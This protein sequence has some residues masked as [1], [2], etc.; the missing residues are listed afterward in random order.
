MQKAA[1]ISLV[2][3]LLTGCDDTRMAIEQM[4]RQTAE[5]RA[6]A[7][8]ELATRLKANPNV[9]SLGDIQIFLSADL[10]AQALT[11]LTDFS[12]QLPERPDVTIKLISA[13]PEL[14]EGVAAINLNLQ[15][16]RGTLKVNVKGVA[17]LLPQ[18]L[19]PARL[20]VKMRRQEANIFGFKMSADLPEF[21]LQKAEPMKFKLV[22]ERLAPHASWGPFSADIKGFVADF[23]QLKINDE[24]NKKLPPIE[25]PIENILKVDQPIQQKEFP[26][27]DGA[28]VA[29]LN[30]PAVSWAVTFGLKDVIVL[31]RGIHL[32]GDFSN[33]GSAQ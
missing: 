3:L 23:A 31:P 8:R 24:L 7:A 21:T 12:V 19:Q 33:P 22:V 27:K 2:T 29:G 11:L 10:I 1:C 26:L 25:V 30:T 15:A 9:S 5:A 13:V 6:S 18:P 4:N 32:I 16:T 14:S 28:Y 20:E 17:T